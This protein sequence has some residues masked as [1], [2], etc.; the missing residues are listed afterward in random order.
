MLHGCNSVSKEND[1]CSYFCHQVLNF[2]MVANQSTRLNQKNVLGPLTAALCC[3]DV[4]VYWRVRQYT[5]MSLVDV[6]LIKQTKLVTFRCVGRW[7]LLDMLDRAR[8]AVFSPLD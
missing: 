6:V 8:L 1:Y 2:N 5:V 3:S 4:D 7:Y